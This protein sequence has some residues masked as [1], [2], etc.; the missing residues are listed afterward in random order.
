[1]SIALFVMLQSSHFPNHDQQIVEWSPASH[2]LSWSTTMTLY[3]LRSLQTAPPLNGNPLGRNDQ[4]IIQVLNQAL[5]LKLPEGH[6]PGLSLP[7]RGGCS[8]T[9]QKNTSF[10]QTLG[11]NTL[12]LT[13]SP[14]AAEHTA[15]HV[16]R[17]MLLEIVIGSCHIKPNKSNQQVSSK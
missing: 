8:N 1:M 13:F 16:S 15:L 6:W 11:F 7:L 12:T 4:M 5:K 14:V 10:F 2:L 17:L 9:W 3:K